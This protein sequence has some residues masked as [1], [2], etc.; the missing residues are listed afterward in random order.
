MGRV[1]G[2]LLILLGLLVLVAGGR[3]ATAPAQLPLP[4]VTPAP[5][6]TAT[7]TPTAS[8]APTATPEPPPPLGPPATELLLPELASDAFTSPRLHLRWRGRGDDDS[9]A[10]AFFVDVRALGLRSPADWRTLVAGSPARSTTFTGEP[11]VAY[12]VRARTRAIGADAFGPL[13]SSTVLVPLDDRS[14]AV[15]RSRGWRKQRRPG[16]WK[17]TTAAATSSKASAKLRFTK[18]RVR[19]IA[20]RFPSA[21]RLAVTLDGR[22]SVVSLAGPLGERQVAFDSGPLRR[23]T[24]RL[25]LRPAGGRVEIDAIAPG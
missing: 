18:R 14:R 24:H 11:G 2:R 9:R 8:P 4:T 19:V 25:T 17:G 23:G 3:A 16:A 1:R 5:T 13:A 12:V 20:R 22:R 7:P 15:K 10:A 6:V 21:G